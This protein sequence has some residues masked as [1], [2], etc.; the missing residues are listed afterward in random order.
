MLKVLNI[1]WPEH[2]F[3]KKLFFDS[4][5]LILPAFKNYFNCLITYYHHW[6][7]SLVDN[8][9]QKNLINCPS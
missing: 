7:V 5:Y 3:D 6:Q 2:F 1:L 4:K 8:E 9:A